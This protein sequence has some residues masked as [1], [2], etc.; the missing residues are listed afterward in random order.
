MAD[1]TGF[2]GRIV[3]DETKPDGTPRKLL[4]TSKLEALGWTPRIP[5][6]AGIEETYRWYLAS[7]QG[8]RD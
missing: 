7:L 3:F 5:L 4:D 2:E 6:R 8:L 1:V